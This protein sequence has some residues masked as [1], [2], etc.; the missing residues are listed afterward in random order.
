MSAARITTELAKQIV[1]AAENPG[2]GLGIESATLLSFD[3]ATYGNRLRYYS[4]ELVDIPVLSSVDPFN[5]RAGDELALLTF[6]P[7]KGRRRRGIGEFG[8]LGRIVRPGENRDPVL[9]VSDGEGGV[10]RIAAGSIGVTGGGSIVVEDGGQVRVIGQGSVVVEQGGAIIVHHDNGVVGAVYGNLDHIGTGGAENGHGLL[11]QADN[12]DDI[13]RAKVTDSGDKFVTAGFDL[14]FT[15]VQ[16]VWLAGE[17]VQLRSGPSSIFLVPD[18]NAVVMQLANTT[19][20]ANMLVTGT[21]TGDLGQVFRI[22]S[23]AADKVDV[24]D[25][26]VDT[27][28][29]LRLRPRTWRDRGEVEQH[30]DTDRWYVGLVAEEVDETGLH[31]FVD[32]DQ[33]AQPAS[34][35]YDRLAIALLKVVQDQQTRLDALDGGGGV[36]PAAGARKPKRL[37]LPVTEPAPAPRSGP[38]PG[39]TVPGSE[40]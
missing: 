13:F 36:Q 7:V 9:E 22:S 5:W 29:V 20:S 4:T 27:S 17:E 2:T 19:G 34:V 23:S 16:Q 35:A 40:A 32:Y 14:P 26:T 38:P 11:V 39:D 30:P 21:S 3:P 1:A 37:A 6:Y 24:E 10:V 12:G 18:N 8:I 28:K 31:E 33:N 15:P 25:L